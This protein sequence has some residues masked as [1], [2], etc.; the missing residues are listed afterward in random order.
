MFNDDDEAK[1][2]LGGLDEVVEEDFGSDDGL[3]NAGES[4]AEDF[5]RDQNTQ[6]DDGAAAPLGTKPEKK[7]KKKKAKQDG[8][9]TAV[10]T[11]GPATENCSPVK[12]GKKDLKDKKKSK[13]LAQTQNAQMMSP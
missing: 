9:A 11:G 12:A 1:R 13:E 3:G 7:K 6:S 5:D 4:G 10:G 2:D 8:T